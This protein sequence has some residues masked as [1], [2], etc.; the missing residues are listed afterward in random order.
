[1][2]TLYKMTMSKKVAKNFA[3]DNFFVNFA[4]S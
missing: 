4:S 2:E 1:M 3:N